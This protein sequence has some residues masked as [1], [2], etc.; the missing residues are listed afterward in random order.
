MPDDLADAAPA[1]LTAGA[2]RRLAEAADGQRDRDL[3]LFWNAT[4]HH[5]VVAE[6]TAAAGTKIADIRTDSLAPARQV[7]PEM[8]QLKHRDGQVL[9]LDAIYDAAF[10]SESSIEKFVIPYY[11]R[12][13]SQ[14]ELADLWAAHADPTVLALLHM[15]PSIYEEYD[16]ADPLHVM[17]LAPG[18][19][20]GT[21]IIPFREWRRRR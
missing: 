21:E 13:Y 19:A 14:A 5:Y 8:V 4:D 7:I 10:W 15:E 1:A 3:A 20:R 9:P 12:L 11:A 18:L 16:G 2:L 17:V 6:R